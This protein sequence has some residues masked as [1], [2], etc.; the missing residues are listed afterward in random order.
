MIYYNIFFWTKKEHKNSLHIAQL[1]VSRL[2]DTV[3]DHETAVWLPIKV[4]FDLIE[5]NEASQL[6]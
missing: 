1:K 6:D 4:L 2:R 3:A 5:H